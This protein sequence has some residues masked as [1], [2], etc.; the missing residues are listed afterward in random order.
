MTI[1]GT[2]TDVVHSSDFTWASLANKPLVFPPSSHS[3]PLSDVTGLGT[4]VAAALAIAI[5]SVGGPVVKDGDVGAAIG[6][7]LAASGFVSASGLRTSSGNGL[8]LAT[9]GSYIAGTR[10]QNLGVDGKARLCNYAAT[11]GVYLDTTTA[12][13]LTLRNLADSAYGGLSLNAVNVYSGTN[14]TGILF[15]GG[16]GTRMLISSNGLIGFGSSSVDANTTDSTVSRITGGG[17]IQVGSGGTANASGTLLLARVGATAANSIG[18]NVGRTYIDGTA[19]FSYRDSGSA[20][21]T[22]FDVDNSGNVTASGNAVF[23][24]GS[25]YPLNLGQD[26]SRGAYLTSTISAV[27]FGLCYPVA[28]IIF[29][30]NGTLPVT[31]TVSLGRA[32]Y[33]FNNFFAKAVNTATFTSSNPNYPLGTVVVKQ[34]TGT[35]AFS[36]GNTGQG[37]QLNYYLDGSE[38][39]AI[40]AG[41]D[42]GVRFQSVNGGYF[43]PD[44]GLTLQ[45]ALNS[46]GVNVYAGNPGLVV[47]DRLN[48]AYG[49]ITCGNLFAGGSTVNYFDNPTTGGGRWQT[50]YAGTFTF[51]S[52]QSAQS[53]ILQ[54]KTYEGKLAGLQQYDVGHANGRRLDVFSDPGVA[55][56]IRPANTLAATFDTSGNSTFTGTI[57]FSQSRFQ[58]PSAQVLQTQCFD[59]SL[60]AWQETMRSQASPTGA[61]WSVF[62]ATPII[63]QTLPAAATD[64]ATTQTLC[65]A[66]RS[67]LLNFGFSN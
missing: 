57:G 22:K 61:K 33:R 46:Y 64:A 8:L 41:N 55:I 14:R 63:Q 49:P 32:D 58:Q 56:T 17:G 18:W 50:P 52:N 29:P 35:G 7:S 24:S 2:P 23:G 36:N 3:H 28:N 10:F 15:D 25:S 5:G 51:Q 4:G 53:M 43:M 16:T 6:S 39:G 9:N 11:G 27:S 1:P 20:Y 60:A 21:A 67:L 13:T 47:R 34:I 26:V 44:Y 48:T 37:I 42:A 65:N 45:C 40:Y 12:D 54:T 59:T 62:G 30:C 31:D 66:I 19:G 38:R